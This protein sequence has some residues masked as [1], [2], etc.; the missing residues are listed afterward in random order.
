M[1]KFSVSYI[2][3]SKKNLNISQEKIDDLRDNREKLSSDKNDLK[4]LD[5]NIK[6]NYFDHADDVNFIQDKKN[7]EVENHD[8]SDKTYDNIRAIQVESIS[9]PILSFITK[10]VRPFL[11]A[12][13]DNMLI[14]MGIQN[15]L[16]ETVDISSKLKIHIITD[17]SQD[18]KRITCGSNV[19]ISLKVDDEYGNSIRTDYDNQ[20]FLLTIGRSNFTRGLELGLI[21]A[22][23]EEEREIIAPFDLNIG[24]SSFAEK[25]SKSTKKA[26]FKVKVHDITEDEE[27]NNI[28]NSLRYYDGMASLSRQISCGDFVKTNLKLLNAKGD[29]LY[30]KPKNQILYLMLGSN[31]SKYLEQILLG[32]HSGGT[33]IAL[34]GTENLETLKRVP[35]LKGIEKILNEYRGVVIEL[36][37]TLV[38]Q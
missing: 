32:V 18:S 33:R 28:Q 9:S 7:T 36:S 10:T 17:G 1:L 6:I 21:G 35:A 23:I 22:K 2:F 16:R 34:S 29:I 25:L 14:R 38:S 31:T 8:E 19:E 15:K 11:E 26:T 27:L 13:I 5:Q 24:I 37:P 4:I 30:E 20:K 12:R 3:L